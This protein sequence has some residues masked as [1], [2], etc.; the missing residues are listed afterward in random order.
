MFF[1]CIYE[2]SLLVTMMRCLITAS[3]GQLERRAA[4]EVRHEAVEQDV[5]AVARAAHG[6]AQRGRAGRVLRQRRAVHQRRARQ[7]HGVRLAPLAAVTPSALRT[8]RVI[9]F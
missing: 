1:M 4:G 2:K 9:M 8:H 5:F 7:H 6:L 3:L